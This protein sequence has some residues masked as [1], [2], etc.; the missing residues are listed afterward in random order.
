M[1]IRII[2]VGKAGKEIA[3][4]YSRYVRM[5]A[6]EVGFIELAHSKKSQ[7]AQIKQDETG[8]IINKLRKNAYVVVLDVLGKQISSS[9][10]SDLFSRQM[11][12]GC[13]VDFVIG[14]AFG[15]DESIMSHANHCLSLSK[16]TMPH[17][18][19]KLFLLEQI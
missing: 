8:A 1:K 19:A 14:G 3:D 12:L 9:E 13:N 2:S 11:M 4:L 10:F 7:P 5:A 6:W 17:Q 18:L 16:M 15:L